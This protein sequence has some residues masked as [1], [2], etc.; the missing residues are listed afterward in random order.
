MTSLE[1]QG[2]GAPGAGPPSSARNPRRDKPHR[3]TTWS[4]PPTARDLPSGEKAN[5]SALGDA[6]AQARAAPQLQHLQSLRIYREDAGADGQ[7]ALRRRF[8]EALEVVFA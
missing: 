7:E 4:L 3:R 6:G 5:K 1:R 8:G 2:A